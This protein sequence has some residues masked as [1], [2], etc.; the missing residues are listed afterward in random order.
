M[1]SP[2]GKMTFKDAAF[3]L[4]AEVGKAMHYGALSYNASQKRMISTD[5]MTPEQTMLASIR[6]E[7]L[8]KGTKSRFA[9]TKEPGVYKL[10]AYGKRQA[11]KLA[12]EKSDERRENPVH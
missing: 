8:H 6:A 4:L 1:G 7:I 12:K 3:A 2:K 5:G 11:K 9:T 10:S